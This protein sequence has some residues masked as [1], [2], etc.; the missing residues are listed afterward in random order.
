MIVA[1]A[2][3]RAKFGKAADV[4]AHM[5]AQLA[6]LSEEQLA[7]FQPRLLTDISGRFD[8]VVM[9][10]THANLATYEQMRAVF[11]A[12]QAASG[13][14]SPMFDLVESGSNEYWTIET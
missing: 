2:I 5:K 14:P 7:A 11:F 1:R 8:T 10:T 9:E 3:F 4:V 13:E 12:Q 6:N